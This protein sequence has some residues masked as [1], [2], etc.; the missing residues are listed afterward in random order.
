MASFRRAGRPDEI[1]SRLHQDKVN[2]F[3][4]ALKAQMAALLPAPVG[5]VP[6]LQNGPGGKKR[7]NRVEAQFLTSPAAVEH[8]L[9]YRV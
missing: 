8:R 6:V 2:L 5:P 1:I 7:L 9:L 4:S 3:V